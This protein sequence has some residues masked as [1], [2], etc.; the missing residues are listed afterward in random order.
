MGGEARIGLKW[1]GKD[2]DLWA[3]VEPGGIQI[4][5]TMP[6]HIWEEWYSLLKKRLTEVLGYEIVNLRGYDFKYFDE[7][8]SSLSSSYHL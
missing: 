8:T 2:I 7:L 4:A 6:D 5:G 1:I 3:S